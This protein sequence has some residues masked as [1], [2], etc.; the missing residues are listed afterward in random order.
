[1]LEFCWNNDVLMRGYS[2]G[3]CDNE[4]IIRQSDGLGTIWEDKKPQLVLRQ[5]LPG[6]NL[7]SGI[8]S[9]LFR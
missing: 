8:M 9:A 3:N 6:H 7:E 4:G 1:M 5:L 2:R